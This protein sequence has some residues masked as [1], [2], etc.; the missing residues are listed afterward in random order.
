MAGTES[1]ASG[2][3]AGLGPLGNIV[4][5]ILGKILDPGLVTALSPPS[6]LQVAPVVFQAVEQEG[7]WKPTWLVGEKDKDRR[8]ELEKQLNSNSAPGD[9]LLPPSFFGGHKPEFWSSLARHNQVL[10][11]VGTKGAVKNSKFVVDATW[12]GDGLEIWGGYAGLANAE[13]FGSI[14]NDTAACTLQAMPFGNYY[15]AQVLIAWSGWLNPVGPAYYEFRGAIVLNADGGFSG[16]SSGGMI[17]MASMPAPTGS[18]DSSQGSGVP[19]F[20]EYWTRGAGEPQGV[21]WDDQ[22]GFS[23]DL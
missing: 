20:M 21:Q 8:L 16:S 4:T 10:F 7:R 17:T 2:G 13:G 23:M 14:Y 18:P 22:T 1:A 9:F 6:A 3:V 11:N 19:G 5:E 12:W 15:P